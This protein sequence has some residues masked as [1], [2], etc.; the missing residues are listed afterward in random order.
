MQIDKEFT[1]RMEMMAN[2][3]LIMV[4]KGTYTGVRELLNNLHW[5]TTVIA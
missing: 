2:G 1:M 3:K 4:G 5:L